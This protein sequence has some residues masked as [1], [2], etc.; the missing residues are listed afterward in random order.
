MPHGDASMLDR[1]IQGRRGMPGDHVESSDQLLGFRGRL[2]TLHQQSGAR[3]A[4]A[5]LVALVLERVHDE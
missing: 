4:F 2:K 5:A 1:V 3:R